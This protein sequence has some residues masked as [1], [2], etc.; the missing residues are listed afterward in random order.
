MADGDDGVDEEDD[1]QNEEDNDGWLAAED[2]LGTE[3]DDDE[4]RELRKKNRNGSS[5]KMRVLAPCMGGLPH[6]GME[7]GDIQFIIEGFTPK[8]A[9][10]TLTSHAGCVITPDVSICLDAYPPSATKE[11]K[12]T[13]KK[14]KKSGRLVETACK[15]RKTQ[16]QALALRPD[17]IANPMIRQITVVR[18]HQFTEQRKNQRKIQRRGRR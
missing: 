11:T 3:D 18:P 9:L 6:D 10:D 2:D 5:G 14:E 12:P 17:G 4:T 13:K 16:I 15:T 7:D 1:L 8:G